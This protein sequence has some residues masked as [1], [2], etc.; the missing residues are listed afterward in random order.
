MKICEGAVYIYFKKLV[1]ETEDAIIVTNELIPVLRQTH[2]KSA[3]PGSI[4][5]P[6][7]NWA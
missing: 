1:F 3:T 7:L 4:I 2:D 6:S 5:A